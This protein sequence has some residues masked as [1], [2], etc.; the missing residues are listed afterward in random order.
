M[1][2]REG[3]LVTIEKGLR[4]QDSQSSWTIISL[5]N[6]NFYRSLGPMTIEAAENLAEDDLLP[7]GAA[8]RHLGQSSRTCGLDIHCYRY[9]QR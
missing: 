8:S 4:T 3:M 7:A 1:E 2:A 6:L 5:C 9:L